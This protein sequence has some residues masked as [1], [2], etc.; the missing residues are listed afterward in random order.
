MNYFFP[1]LLSFI[2]V[3][4]NFSFSVLKNME[5]NRYQNHQYPMNYF[6]YTAIITRKCTRWH[7]SLM[8]TF[9][10]SS[11]HFIVLLFLLFSFYFCVCLWVVSFFKKNITIL[12]TLCS[13][14]KI[15]VWFIIFIVYGFI[16]IVF[17]FSCSF[18]CKA[19][20]SKLSQYRMFLF[21]YE[22]HKFLN[23]ACYKYSE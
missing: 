10:I 2:F 15:Y 12:T 18:V 8:T 6:R 17:F 21:V 20:G 16:T 9:Y 22:R 19:K 14:R 11:S 7:L 5:K 1:E 4:W 23:I 13:K 3:L